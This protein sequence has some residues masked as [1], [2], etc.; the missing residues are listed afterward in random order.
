MLKMSTEKIWRFVPDTQKELFGG[1]LI[2]K[3][4]KKIFLL[5]LLPG[6][7]ILTSKALFPFSFDSLDW[8]V[9]IINLILETEHFSLLSN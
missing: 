6:W 9:L 3:I 2:G 1:I 4:P 7:Q 8:S 5:L